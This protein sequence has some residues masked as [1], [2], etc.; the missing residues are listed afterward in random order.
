M[1]NRLMKYLR[2][3][4]LRFLFG[5]PVKRPAVS[6]VMPLAVEA[7]LPKQIAVDGS[8]DPYSTTWRF[9]KTWADGSLKNARERNDNLNKDAT[10]TAV[11]RGEIKILKELVAL[12]EPKRGLLRE[13]DE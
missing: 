5:E 12:T 4:L 7:E 8:I 1:W 13:E 11:L 9:V 10:Q 3:A 2:Q 6:P